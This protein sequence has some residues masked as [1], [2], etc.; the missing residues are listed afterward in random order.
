MPEKAA[1]SVQSG[2]DIGHSRAGRFALARE[3]WIAGVAGVLIVFL[4]CI[5][6]YFSS[7]H[8]PGPA[9]MGV[10]G[11]QQLTSIGL[12]QLHALEHSSDFYA[13]YFVAIFAIFVAVWIVV[14][15]LIFWRKADDRMAYFGSLI[16]A[17][18][19]VNFIVGNMVDSLPASWWL[20]V[21]SVRFFGGM[22]LAVFFYIFPD[23]KFVP[24]WTRWLLIG[25]VIHE[26]FGDTI[27]A[28]APFNPFLHAN[29]LDAIL[30]F[31]LLLSL[32][33]VQVYRYRRV[34]NAV[35]RQ[36]TKW[37]VFG[38]AIAVLGFAATL[39]VG[40][41]GVGIDIM[42]MP[43]VN[44]IANTA[45]I[46]FLLIIPISVGFA[47]SR[48]HLWDIDSII[49]RALV[50]GSL[51]GI[52]GALYAGLVI[53]LESLV[54]VI[55]GQSADQPVVL[56]ISTLIIAALF[57][58]ARKRIQT[59]IDHR[60]YRKKYDAHKTLAAF[61]AILRNEVDLGQLQEN[62]LAV[63]EET[64]QPAHVSLWVRQA[65]SESKHE[66]GLFKS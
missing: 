29:W 51:T 4:A 52:L 42:S 2:M 49:N 65:Q 35:Q 13:S 57:Q 30:F 12:R 56:V 59:I 33:I 53:G 16:L 44:M 41:V 43:I 24:R 40:S 34:S 23:G 37:V 47:I 62:L 48:S 3:L 9:G 45:L 8:L 1:S 39:I 15:V 10:N 17:I 61:S 50:Y 66:V 32:V 36:Q 38:M 55:T 63:V 22:G 5:P 7:L 11:D 28:N 26:L 64:K 54:R 60:F 14:G 31:G 6:S 27:F 21:Q 19:P 46:A 20:P 58:P 25:W 18:F